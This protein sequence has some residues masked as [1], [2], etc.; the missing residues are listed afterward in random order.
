MIVSSATS[1]SC[2]RSGFGECHDH[3]SLDLT[4]TITIPSV[5]RSGPDNSESTDTSTR[6]SCVRCL[7]AR[8][9]VS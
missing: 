8:R 4:G 6:S 7:K 1:R 9:C 2:R 3:R 5:P